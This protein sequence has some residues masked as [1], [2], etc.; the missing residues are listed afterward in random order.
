MGAF[1]VN[2]FRTIYTLLDEQSSFMSSKSDKIMSVCEQLA[3]VVNS[4]D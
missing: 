4:T 1:N 3:R 2:E